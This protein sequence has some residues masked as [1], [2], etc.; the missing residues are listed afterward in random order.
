MSLTVTKYPV[1]NIGENLFAGGSPIIIEFER[2]DQSV[3]TTEQ[4]ASNTIKINIGVNLAA[5]LNVNEYIYF[6]SGIYDLSAKVLEIGATYIRIATQWA[7]NTTGGY[8]NYKQNYYV[9]LDIIDPTNEN[10]KIL[11]FTLK[12]DGD[13]RG[14]ISINLA[15]INDLNDLEFPNFAAIN[16]MTASRIKFDIKYRQIWRESL[17]SVYTR[18]SN[19]IIIYPAKENATIET[20]PNT[21]ETLEYYLGY[22]NGAVFLHSDA[23]PLGA[24]NFVFYYDELDINKQVINENNL[25]GSISSDKYGRIFVPLCNLTFL[26]NT[27][28]FSIKKEAATIPEFSPV[29]FTNDFNI[30]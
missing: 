25:I 8:I 6:N 24:D 12:D 26:E 4:G 17:A 21:M 20:F 23:D 27:K 9:E 30:L 16:E 28:Y 19:P 15:I 10:I 29:D 2:K 3:T 22:N 7:G 18:I 5:S 1:V 13:T 14:L 11:P